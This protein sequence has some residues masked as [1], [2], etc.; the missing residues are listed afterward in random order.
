VWHQV[1]GLAAVTLTGVVLLHGWKAPGW[2]IG[3][4]CI[5][6]LAGTALF[7]L[8]AAG[9]S[10]QPEPRSYPAYSEKA[11][12][13]AGSDASWRNPRGE[14][15]STRPVGPVKRADFASSAASRVTP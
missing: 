3:A 8:A 10:V 5:L 12:P 11:A 1:V 7:A 13:Q 2:A 14:P 15:A 6:G 9:R 4:F